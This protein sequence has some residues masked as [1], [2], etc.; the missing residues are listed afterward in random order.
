[1]LTKHF[2]EFIELLNFHKVDYLIVGGYAVGFH[3]HPRYTGDLDIWIKISE[4]NAERM[5]LVLNEFPAPKNLFVKADFLSETPLSGGFFGNEPFRIDIL[6][7]IDGVLFD[8]CFPNAQ[9]FNFE[10]TDLYFIHYNDL[11]KNKLSTSRL[12]DKADIE[13]LEKRRNKRN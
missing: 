1:M 6:N 13:E 7:S 4:Q 10:G 9:K 3:G 11:K 12:K 5:M 8:E 2:K